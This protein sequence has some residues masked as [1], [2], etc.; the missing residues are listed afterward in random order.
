MKTSIIAICAYTSLRFY[1]VFQEKENL[2]HASPLLVSLLLPEGIGFVFASAY[3]RR[4][5]SRKYALK[6]FHCHERLFFHALHTL[7]KQAV[8]V[9]YSTELL[10]IR[11]QSQERANKKQSVTRCVEDTIL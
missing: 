1:F 3:G 4:K 8:P 7:A 10:N 6:S 11:V 9:G 5:K 2:T